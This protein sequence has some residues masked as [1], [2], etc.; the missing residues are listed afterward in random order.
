MA[1]FL[2]VSL[3]TWVGYPSEWL[4]F[5]VAAYLVWGM[6]ALVAP[7]CVARIGRRRHGWSG[8]RA[9]STGALVCIGFSLVLAVFTVL[10]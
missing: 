10:Y 4:P 9:V 5:V 6:G 1:G 2:L 3:V 8:Q 7:I